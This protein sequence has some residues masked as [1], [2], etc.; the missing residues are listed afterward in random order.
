MES[1]YTRKE[2]AMKND[3]W[4]ELA[5]EREKEGWKM[6]TTPGLI[7]EEMPPNQFGADSNEEWCM[8]ECRRQMDKGS[9]VQVMYDDTGFVCWV[10]RKLA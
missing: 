7:N 10:E 1:G 2:Q 4:N 5:V 9:K 3:P 6:V 8:H